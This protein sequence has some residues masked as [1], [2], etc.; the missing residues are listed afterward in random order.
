MARRKREHLSVYTATPHINP[1][2]A[3]E[4]RN[5]YQVN[6]RHMTEGSEVSIRGERGRFRFI[7]AVT[8]PAGNHWLDFIGGTKGSEVFRSFHAERVRTVHRIAKTRANLTNL[9]A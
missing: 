1:S 4:V 3:W 9:A 8:T 2:A 6:G 5:T 7:R